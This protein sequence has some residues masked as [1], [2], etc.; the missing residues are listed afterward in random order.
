MVMEKAK[1][2]LSDS[3][4]DELAFL[5]A[6]EDAPVYYGFPLIKE[7]NREGF[8]FGAITDFLEPD[9]EEGCTFGDGF[10]QAPDGS[11]A[12]LIWITSSEPYLRTKIEAEADRWGVFEVGFIQPIK[13]LDD[14]IINFE[15]VLPLIKEKYRER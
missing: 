9:C 11:R 1:K 5:L 4:N 15:T 2:L 3:D 13:K 8:V 12:G 14:L 10:I 6:P 7:T